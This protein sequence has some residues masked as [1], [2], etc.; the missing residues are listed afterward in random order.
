MKGL[1]RKWVLSHYDYDRNAEKLIKKSISLWEKGGIFNRWRAIRLYNIIRSKYSCN[2]WPGIKMGVNVYISHAQNI[3]IGPTAE[4][5]NNCRIYPSCSFASSIVG[6]EKKNGKRRHAKIGDNCIV[7]G[8]SI[9]VGDIEIG[10]NVVIG[11]GAVVR[12]DI[13]SYAILIGN[14]AKIVGFTM[15]P[16]EAY[17]NELN[18]YPKEERIPLEVLEKNYQKYFLDRMK[19]IRDFAKK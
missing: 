17:Q 1:I 2:I 16:D 18:N 7:G 10:H 11:A 15:R 4:I 8:G 12:K 5:G 13:P 14:P 3:T 6:D 9:L 19:D